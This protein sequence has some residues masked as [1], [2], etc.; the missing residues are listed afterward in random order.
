V[1]LQ[2][3]IVATARSVIGAQYQWGGED[4]PGFDCSGLTQWAY[5]QNGIAIPRTSEEQA[6]AGYPV[7]YSDLQP[8]DLIIYYP[9]ASHVALYSGNGMV[10]QAADYGI[11]VEEVPIGSAGP[12]NQARRFLTEIPMT[13]NLFADVSEFQTAVDDSYPYRVLTIRSNDGSYQD[14]K[15]T[16]NYQWCVNA[17]DAGKLEFFIVYY[18]WRPGETG[19]TTHMGMVNNLGGPHPRMVTMIDLE[20]GG[21]PDSDQTATLEDEY[22]QLAAWLGDERRVIAYANLGDERIMWQFKPAHLEWILAGYGANP[23]DPSLIKLAHQYTD[24]NG[25]GGGLPEGCSPFGNCDMNSADGLDPAAFAAA[26]GINPSG[27]ETPVSASNQPAI[28][29]PADEATQVSQE[30][31]QELIR[32]DMLGGRTLVEALAAVGAA[33]KIPGFSDP[34]QGA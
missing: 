23:D 12:Y 32:W 3:Q 26:C 27:G 17:C 7:A 5:A 21:N 24:G 4:N 14:H 6:Q 11:P 29:K 8:A 9:D 15:F 31:D 30:W 18:Y 1:T 20:S 2:D 33:L 13:D 22:N 19:L 34:T 10:I 28:T 16:Q 25:Y